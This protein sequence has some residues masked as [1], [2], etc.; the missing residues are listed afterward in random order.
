MNTNL[1]L[2]FS[3]LVVCAVL[4]TWA[5]VE[6]WKD[7]TVA[8][9]ICL[10]CWIAAFCSV[11]IWGVN[12][13]L[14]AIVVLMCVLF[15]ASGEDSPFGSA[16]LLP[17]AMYFV[18]FVSDGFSSPGLLMYPIALLVLLYPY[19]KLYGKTHGFTWKLGAKVYMPMLPC[20]A[21][22]WWLA[23]AAYMIFCMIKI[24]VV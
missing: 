22:G 21:A 4:L 16:D 7:S 23:T 2:Q 9:H 10:L 3:S 15:Y 17:L 5:A 20:M 18:T 8:G 12:V 13:I 11:F 14:T 19:G 24:G 1:I 6:D